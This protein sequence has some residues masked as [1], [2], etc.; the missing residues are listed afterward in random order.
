MEGNQ[1]RRTTADE[2]LRVM[3]EGTQ[4]GPAISEVCRRHQIHHSRV[5]RW[6]RL[7]RQEL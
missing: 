3:E 1:G 7:A 4:S 6:K 2:K 5:Y